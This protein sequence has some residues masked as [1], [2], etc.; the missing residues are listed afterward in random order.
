[1]PNFLLLLSAFSERVIDAAVATSLHS[2]ELERRASL[3]RRSYGVAKYQVSADSELLLDG[4]F[5]RPHYMA[6]RA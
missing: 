2:R 3:S 4:H 1:M 5:A 6:G